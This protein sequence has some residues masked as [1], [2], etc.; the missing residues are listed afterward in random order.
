MSWLAVVLLQA[1]AAS[2]VDINDRVEHYPVNGGTVAQLHS[3]M[4]ALGPADRAGVRYP[5]LTQWDVRWNYRFDERGG[6]CRV[7]DPRVK[8]EVVITLPEWRAPAGTDDSLLRDWT[9]FTQRLTVHEQGH[10]EFGVRAADTVREA[11]AATPPQRGCDAL[12]EELNR[13]AQ[14]ALDAAIQAE[15]DYDDQTAHGI[16]QGAV[17]PPGESTDAE[18]SASGEV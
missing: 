11:L 7:I 15:R 17:F 1:G 4:K 16:T 10:R 6:R 3:Q 2:A 18:R 9:T 5:G 13:R 12:E 14:G 8:L